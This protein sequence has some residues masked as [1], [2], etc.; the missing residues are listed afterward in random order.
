MEPTREVSQDVGSQGQ[1]NSYSSERRPN[2]DNFISLAPPVQ[3]P[4]YAKFD[5]K[6]S[7]QL[8]AADNPQVRQ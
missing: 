8:R 2:N 4:N 3:R 7:V 5:L 1:P 6:H